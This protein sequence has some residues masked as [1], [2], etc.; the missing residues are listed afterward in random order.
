MREPTH[1][2]KKDGAALMFSGGLDSYLAHRVFQPERLVF[3]AAGHRYAAREWRAVEELGLADRVVTDR[4]LDLSGWERPDAI[5]PL[6]NLLFAAV[7]SRHADRV[8]LGSLEGEI[9]WDKTPEFYWTASTALSH[10]YRTSYWCEGRV[11]TVESPTAAFTKAELVAEALRH[12][13]TREEMAA[14]VS[15]YEPD[16]FCGRCASCFKRAVATKLNGWV[17]PYASDPFQS[18]VCLSSVTKAL[19][20]TYGPKRSREVLEACGNPASLDDVLDSLR[21]VAGRERQAGREVHLG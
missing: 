3:C 10:C 21:G 7:G 4:T 20:G 16:G 5:V 8:W 14:T 12:G 15:C 17:E 2:K 9:N 11:V 13:V 19:S 18:T 6:R 1:E